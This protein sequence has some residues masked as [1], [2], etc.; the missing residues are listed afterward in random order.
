MLANLPDTMLHPVMHEQV[1]SGTPSDLDLR[2][3]TI[4]LFSIST[5]HL[6]LLCSINH[7]VKK[8]FLC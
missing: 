8:L 5:A 4:K 7:S 2:L 1:L 3:S 6:T